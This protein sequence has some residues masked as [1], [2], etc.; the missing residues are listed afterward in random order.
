MN[1]IHCLESVHM[2]IRKLTIKPLLAQGSSLLQTDCKRLALVQTAPGDCAA[3][4]LNG[5][6][7]LCPDTSTAAKLAIYYK[8]K[9]FN[10]K[11]TTLEIHL[12]YHNCNQFR[13]HF[14]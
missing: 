1:I 3:K 10:Y 12:I 8:I 9:H 6:P 2:I 14:V 13:I 7:S 5:I 4:G 11:F